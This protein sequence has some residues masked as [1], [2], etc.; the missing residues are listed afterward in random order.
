MATA[1]CVGAASSVC[2][3]S[4][5]LAGGEPPGVVGGW[6]M[7]RMALKMLQHDGVRASQF[8]KET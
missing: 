7:L 6:V 3:L 1:Y 2:L 8:M 4:D 5:G